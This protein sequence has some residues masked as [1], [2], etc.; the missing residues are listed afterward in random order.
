MAEGGIFTWVLADFGLAERLS[1]CDHDT[2]VAG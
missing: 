1:A 2:I